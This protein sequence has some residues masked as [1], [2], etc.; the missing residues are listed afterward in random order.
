V[1]RWVVSGGRLVHAVV[2]AQW[3][4]GQAAR[5]GSGR[6]GERRAQGMEWKWEWNE[7]QRQQQAEIV[8]VASGGP[9]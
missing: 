3:R 8:A 1:V 4:T 2:L 5:G 7:Q 9:R 6:Q